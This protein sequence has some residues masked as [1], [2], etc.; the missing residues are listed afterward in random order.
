MSK[1]VRMGVVGLAF[2][3]FHVRTL[4]AMPEVD[5]MGVADHNGDRCERVASQYSCRGFEDAAE[6]VD[7]LELDALSICVSPRSRA[8]VLSL[9]IEHDLAL[10]VEKPWAAHSRQAAELSEIC[11]GSRQPIMTGFSFRFHPAVRRARDLVRGELGAVRLGNGSYVFEWLPPADAW[12][13]DPEN[14]GG[15]FNENSCHLFDVICTLAGTPVELFAWGVSSGD[16]PSE[17]GATV[18][19]RFESGGTVTLSVGGVGARAQANYPWLETFT[20]QG[21]LRVTG[22]NHVWHRVEW[23]RRGEE[24]AQVMDAAPE[25]LGRTRYTDAFE[26]FVDCV[27]S[28]RTPEAGVRDGMVMVRIAEAIRESVRTGRPV[29]TGAV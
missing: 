4:A 3:E 17:V 14:G 23:A 11:A 12:L 10:F 28:G 15:F 9:A 8:S 29:E 1:R 2:G 6:M 18:A 27:R 24:A 7:A 26:H 16:R 13:W 21:W 22:S 20:E 19:L 5:L 25:Q